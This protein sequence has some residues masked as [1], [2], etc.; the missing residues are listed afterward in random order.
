MADGSFIVME[1]YDR[2]KKFLGLS[3]MYKIENF[4]PENGDWYWA[5]YK[6]DG[7]TAASGKVNKCLD[8]HS[9]VKT[10]DY[11]KSRHIMRR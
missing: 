8:C 11:I 7:S 10:N 4:N 1:N 5:E 2:Q 9:D 6:P 3:V